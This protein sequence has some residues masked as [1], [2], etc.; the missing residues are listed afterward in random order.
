MS[1]VI[2]DF[3]CPLCGEVFSGQHNEEE[4]LDEMKRNFGKNAVP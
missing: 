4:A 3:K 1:I 2:K